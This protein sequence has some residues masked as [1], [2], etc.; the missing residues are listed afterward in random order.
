MG[1]GKQVTISVGIAQYAKGTTIAG[2]IV[3]ADQALYRAKHEGRDRVALT[4]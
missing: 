2:L 4:E 3:K 1:P